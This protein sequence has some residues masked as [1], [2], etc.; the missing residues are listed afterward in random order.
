MNVHIGEWL[1]YLLLGKVLLSKTQNLD[2]INKINNIFKW[3]IKSNQLIK[4]NPYYKRHHKIKKQK[5][6]PKNSFIN[7]YIRI[8]T[9]IKIPILINSCYKSIRANNKKITKT[10]EQGK[11]QSKEN[12]FHNKNISKYPVNNQVH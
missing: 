2:A 5:I 4:Q 10:L 1:Y 12:H 7:T 6:K 11:F 3:K 8:N 9:Y